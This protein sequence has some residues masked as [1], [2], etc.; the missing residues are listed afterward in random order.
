M[1]RIQNGQH[2]S[3]HKKFVT[4]NGVHVLQ[5]TFF[6]YHFLGKTRMNSDNTIYKLY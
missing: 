3:D 2:V 1:K 6:T 5:F 4:E